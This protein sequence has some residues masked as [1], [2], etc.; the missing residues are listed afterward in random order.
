[1]HGAVFSIQLA[2]RPED[3]RNRTLNRFNGRFGSAEWNGRNQSNNYNQGYTM[4]HLFMCHRDLR[5]AFLAFMKELV[6]T[7][8]YDAAFEK[9]FA[10]V[11]MKR[12]EELWKAYVR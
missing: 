3:T 8:S 7:G 10:S 5:P 1:M 2:R 6:K 4:V 12:A 11:S 9:G